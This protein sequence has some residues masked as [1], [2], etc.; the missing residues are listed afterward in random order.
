[1]TIC[2]CPR[3]CER[4]H[5]EPIGVHMIQGDFIPQR[6]VTLD[7]RVDLPLGRGWF[8]A[9]RSS[10]AFVVDGYVLIRLAT[11]TEH[12]YVLNSQTCLRRGSRGSFRVQEIALTSDPGM[13]I[14]SL[15]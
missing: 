4:H 14:K 5:T 12:D 7:P 11:R 10:T 1:M 2:M 6:L 9:H 3:D 15:I 13:G 8:R